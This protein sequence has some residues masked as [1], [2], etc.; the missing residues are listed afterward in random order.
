MKD[1]PKFPNATRVAAFAAGLIFAAGAYGQF[2]PDPA[3]FDAKRNGAGSGNGADAMNQAGNNPLGGNI[4]LV[5]E[6]NLPPL[7]I[8]GLSIDGGMQGI[9]GMPSSGGGMQQSSQGSSGGLPMGGSSGGGMQQSGQQSPFPPPSS[10]SQGQ[11]QGG[12]QSQMGQ[13]PQSQ[14]QQGMQG[15][16]QGQMSQQNSQQGQQGQQGQQSKNGQMSQSGQQGTQQDG[17]TEQDMKGG[18]QGNSNSQGQNSPLAGQMPPPPPEQA[19]GDS[20]Q[21]I[22]PNGELASNDEGSED[23]T[24]GSSQGAKGE[25]P[26]N[27]K[28]GQSQV[29]QQESDPSAS[30]GQAMPE[31]IG[32]AS[33][34]K[35]GTGTVDDVAVPANL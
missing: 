30:D 6:S 14:S 21:Q 18:Q 15:G 12:Q 31:D 8:P 25:K 9:P 16:E 4:I 33:G 28:K 3:I 35:R 13:M 22:D 24:G 32:G 10:Q 11:Q 1:L 29:G 27:G 17:L 34:S 7:Q 5:N 2:D 23:G 19:I 26:K 20:S